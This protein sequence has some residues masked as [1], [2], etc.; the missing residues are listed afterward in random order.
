MT[1]F[2]HKWIVLRAARARTYIV[3]RSDSPFA[4]TCRKTGTF[5]GTFRTL[6]GAQSRAR[7]LNVRVT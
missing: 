3:A 6:D 4:R 2:G 7:E 1:R 5:A